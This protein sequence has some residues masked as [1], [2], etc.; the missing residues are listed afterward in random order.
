MTDTRSAGGRRQDVMSVLRDSS[1]PMSIS[2]I[3]ERLD[4]HPNTVRFHLQ[5]LVASAQAE[6]V[7]LPPTGPGRPALLFQA[8]RR[9]NPGGPRNYRLLAE[10][11]TNELAADPHPATRAM[12]AGRRWGRRLTV[13]PPATRR[14]GAPRRLTRLLDEIGFEPELRGSGKD[15][16]IRLHHCPFLDLTANGSRIVCPIHLGLMQG[17]M[18]QLDPAVSVSDLQPFAEPDLCVARLD[19][20]AAIPKGQT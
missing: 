12:D 8:S 2:E 15:I 14:E 9:M 13:P 6:R 3:A 7:D 4:V 16:Q 18:E 5:T 1:A 10:I 17:A 19:R 20:N 11:L